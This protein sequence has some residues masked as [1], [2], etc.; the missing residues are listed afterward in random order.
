MICAD[1]DD[2]NHR[3][4]IMIAQAAARKQLELTKAAILK[5]MARLDRRPSTAIVAGEG[6]FLARRLVKL[7][8]PDAKLIS[9]ARKIGAASSRC[10]PAHA[11]AVLARESMTPRLP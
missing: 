7:A 6:E 8:L 5:V 9:L 2:F 4:A 3:D 11:L 1:G 10:A